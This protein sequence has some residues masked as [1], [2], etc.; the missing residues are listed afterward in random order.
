MRRTPS[1][2]PTP[3]RANRLVSI[4]K[5]NPRKQVMLLTATPVNNALGDLHSAA[6]VLHRPR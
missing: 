4:L 6:V 3:Q 2:T 1:A 5:G